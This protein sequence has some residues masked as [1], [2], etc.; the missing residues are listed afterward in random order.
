MGHGSSHNGGQ[1]VVEYQIRIDPLMLIMD[2]MICVTPP[3]GARTLA[4]RIVKKYDV[5]AG[6]RSGCFRGFGSGQTR[7]GPRH[8]C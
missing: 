7:T 1:R 4:E 6:R 5:K 3:S 2:R 8:G